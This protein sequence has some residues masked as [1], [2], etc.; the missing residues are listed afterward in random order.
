MKVESSLIAV[1]SLIFVGALVVLVMTH[2]QGF[3]TFV[4]SGGTFVDNTAGLLAGDN[5]S[6]S[7]YPVG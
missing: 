1:I 2:P 3:G 6:Q 5:Y 4:A 7:Q